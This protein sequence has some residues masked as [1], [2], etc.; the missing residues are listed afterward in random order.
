MKYFDRDGRSISQSEW[1]DLFRQWDYGRV[2]ETRI[3]SGTVDTSWVG[4]ACDYER[5]PMIFLTRTFSG[6]FQRGNARAIG[7]DVWSE[8]MDQARVA[9]GKAVAALRQA[10]EGPNRFIRT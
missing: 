10:G 8:T 9:H 3:D 4:M 1:H 6:S 2:N 5:K 7:G